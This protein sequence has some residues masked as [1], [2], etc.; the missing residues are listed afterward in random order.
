MTK[1]VSTPADFQQPVKSVFND[2]NSL[3]DEDF[4][5][6]KKKQF[7]PFTSQPAKNDDDYVQ[8][9]MQ[10]NTSGTLGFTSPPQN[11]SIKTLVKSE[12]KNRKKG[13]KS[14]KVQEFNKSVV[15]DEMVTEEI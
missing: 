8:Q 4:K 7:M 15:E 1:T 9:M 10:A 6:P 14:I 3:D 11:E 12:R 2:F 5:I 13:K